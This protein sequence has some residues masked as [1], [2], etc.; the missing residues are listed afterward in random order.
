MTTK[1]SIILALF[2]FILNTCTG[3]NFV[4]NGDFENGPM[5][6]V[7]TDGI[8]FGPDFDPETNPNDFTLTGMALVESGA[9]FLASESGTNRASG[10]RQNLPAI[11]ETDLVLEFDVVEHTGHN[12]TLSWSDEVDGHGISWDV[13]EGP[14]AG[15]LPSRMDLGGVAHYKLK[16]TEGAFDGDEYIQFVQRGISTTSHVVVDNV[17]LYSESGC[18]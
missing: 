13:L 18:R 14:T 3:N 5:G 9:L 4:I 16:L 7:L 10:A 12:T 1:H 11:V 17:V 6:W 2:P 15:I 8:T